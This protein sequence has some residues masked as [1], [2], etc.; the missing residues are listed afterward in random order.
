[1]PTNL[2]LKNETRKKY[3]FKKV[4]KVKER[5]K[6]KYNKKKLKGDGIIKK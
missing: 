1:L 2:V 3:P 4:V 6:V 5:I